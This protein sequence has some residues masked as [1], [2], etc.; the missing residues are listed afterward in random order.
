MKLREHP[1]M[2]YRS[3]RSWPPAWTWVGGAD[4]QHPKGEVGILKEVK[5]SQINPADR[6]FIYME[7]KDASYIGCL[8]ID[9]HSFCHQIA[10]LLQ[11]CC[12]RPVREIA[13]LDLSHTL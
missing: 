13:D 11:D 6:I 9:H 5:V 2:T 7:Y 12:G 10:R 3:L 4:N 8:L 1:L